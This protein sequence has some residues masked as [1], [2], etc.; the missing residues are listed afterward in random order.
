MLPTQQGPQ[1]AK[2]SSRKEVVFQPKKY[3][4]L[5]DKPVPRHEIVDYGDSDEEIDDQVEQ[6]VKFNGVREHETYHNFSSTV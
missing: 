6:I 5:E 1:T 3:A 2:A 4:E